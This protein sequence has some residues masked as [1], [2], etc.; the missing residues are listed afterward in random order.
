MPF[1]E[2]P[3]NE[4]NSSGTTLESSDSWVRKRPVKGGAP[5]SNGVRASSSKT[6]LRKGVAFPDVL[7]FVNKGMT[8]SFVGSPNGSRRTSAAES[9]VE[10]DGAP[11]GKLMSSERVTGRAMSG[12]PASFSPSTA[13]LA[14]SRIRSLAAAGCSDCSAGFRSTSI[15]R[16]EQLVFQ[17]ADR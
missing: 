7:T 4:L 15:C 1:D 2:R 3:L 16:S 17:E 13:D 11:L 8:I 12:G 6:V 5:F 10:G 9:K 14:R